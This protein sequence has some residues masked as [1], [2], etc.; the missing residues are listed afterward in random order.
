MKH[1]E[2][3]EETARARV[4]DRLTRDEIEKM[5]AAEAAR[6]E[7]ER[8]TEA[9]RER[10]ERGAKL[11]E[12]EKRLREQIEKVAKANASHVKALFDGFRKIETLVGDAERLASEQRGLLGEARSRS[13][14]PLFA[15]RLAFAK[16]ARKAIVRDTLYDFDRLGFWFDHHL[17]LSAR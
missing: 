10:R 12:E 9:E 4:L 17:I 14:D 11:A 7:A 8:A 6:L 5:R 15:E 16:V 2:I 3:N 1:I 13:H